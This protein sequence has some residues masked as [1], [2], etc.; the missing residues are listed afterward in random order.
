MVAQLCSHPRILPSSCSLWF[1]ATY[2]LFLQDLFLARRV[3][4]QWLHLLCNIL[5]LESQPALYTLALPPLIAIQLLL[6]V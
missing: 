2:F 3:G 4:Q 5:E 1:Y 6:K